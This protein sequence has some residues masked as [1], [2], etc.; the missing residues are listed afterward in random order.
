MKIFLV[1]L[2]ILSFLNGINEFRPYDKKSRAG[3]KLLDC[4][5]CS[6]WKDEIKIWEKNKTW[7][8]SHQINSY[9]DFSS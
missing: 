8:A 5:N 3:L 9:N 2:V 6:E 4:I 7:M 1:L